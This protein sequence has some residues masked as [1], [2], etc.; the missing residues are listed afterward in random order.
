MNGREERIC[1]ELGERTRERE[2]ERGV[3]GT[4]ESER[5]G[6]GDRGRESR[7]QQMRVR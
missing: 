2:R 4:T 6:G 5:E 3:H 7:T 1:K